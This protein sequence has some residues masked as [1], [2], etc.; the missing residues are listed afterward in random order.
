MK[1]VIKGWIG[2]DE[3]LASLY[4]NSDDEII[5]FTPI[6]KYKG[7]KIHYSETEWP[8]KRVT[9]TIEVDE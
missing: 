9:I 8:P 6:S 3:E 2:K 4:N 7:R 1:K 5:G